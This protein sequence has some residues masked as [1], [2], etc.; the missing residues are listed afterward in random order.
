MSQ[1]SNKYSLKVVYPD[2]T[3]PTQYVENVTIEEVVGKIKEIEKEYGTGI[4]YYI[5]KIS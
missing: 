1:V 3:V 5:Q 2:Q 4:A